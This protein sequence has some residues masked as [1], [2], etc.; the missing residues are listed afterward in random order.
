MAIHFS[1]EE[2]CAPRDR[3][4]AELENRGLY[5]LLCYRQKTDVYLT[6]YEVFGDCYIQCQLHYADGR[7]FFLT[8]SSARMAVSN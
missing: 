5:A 6:G 8:R 4:S 1:V 7:M 2:L 3:V